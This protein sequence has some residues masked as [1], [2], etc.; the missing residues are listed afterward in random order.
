MVFWLTNEKLRSPWT[1]RAV[2]EHHVKDSETKSWIHQFFP[3]LLQNLVGSILGQA[4]PLHTTLQKSVQWFLSDPA[5]THKRQTNAHTNSTSFVE[6]IQLDLGELSTYK[7]FKS[8]MIHSFWWLVLAHSRFT[9]VYKTDITEI[10]YSWLQDFLCFRFHK[11]KGDAA[12]M[13]IKANHRVRRLP[14]ASM[15]W[16][17]YSMHAIRQ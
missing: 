14:P 13:P 5:E 11:F 6:V 10:V 3:D 9:Y 1:K 2:G 4:S 7:L 15:C 16:D 8:C 12:F 17:P